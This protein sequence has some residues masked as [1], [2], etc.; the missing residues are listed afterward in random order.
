M[1]VA[2]LALL[3]L[4]G[5][6]FFG[7]FSRWC[8]PARNADHYCHYVE[9]DDDWHGATFFLAKI[10][11][12]PSKRAKTYRFEA[13]VIEIT[14]TSNITHPCTGKIIIYLPY[15]DSLSAF[16]TFGD[17]LLALASPQI[18]PSADSNNHFDY[19]RYLFRKGILRTA[20]VPAEQFRIVGHDNSSFT[21]HI[22]NLRQ[23]LLKT[24]RFSQ[25]TPSQQGI[26]EALFLGWN[27]DLD[28]ET[29]QNFRSAGISHLLCVS[30]LHVEI[31]AFAIGWCLSFLGNRRRSRIIRGIIQLAVVWLFVLL[32]QMA[33]ATLRA[34]IMFSFIIV[35]QMFFSKPST[36][37]SIAIS[38]LLL[39]IYN[40]L[41]MF[42]MGL[43]FSYTSVTAIVLFV[44]PMEA[45]LPLPET[46]LQDKKLL[47]S[48]LSKI[49]S[50]FCVSVVAQLALAPFMLYYF[51]SFATYFLIAN[52]VVVPFA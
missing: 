22:S 4:L 23:R 10:T 45:I 25:L 38:A 7:C 47:H 16:V 1:P 44:R 19:R 12:L 32:T 36:L 11:S 8:N 33:P 18:P 30:G 29:K 35:G 5:E 21:A 14:D 26:A 52:M 17:T 20:Y 48:L 46:R 40:P 31:V 49:R 15:S 24:I 42:D 37:N 34:A 39:L 41:L 3:I 43:Q 6:Q 13:E 2:L 27:D 9:N 51:H 28:P 50:L